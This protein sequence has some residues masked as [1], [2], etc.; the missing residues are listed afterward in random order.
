MFL[1][2]EKVFDT[3]WESGI[4]HKLSESEFST[5]FI[6]LI[7]SFL[8]DRT[9]KVLVEGKISTPRKIAAGL[10]QRSVLA[11]ILYFLYINE[12]PA[13][14]G[15][16]LALFADD[17]CIYPAE[18]HKRRVLCKLQRGLTAVNSWCERWNRKLKEGKT[19][20]RLR[21]LDAVIQLNERD[22]PFVNNEM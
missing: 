20:T 18:K 1:D 16:H 15:V 8:T 22:S 6:K 13:A 3:T 11:P 4:L 21:V 2:I 14:P 12:A 5:S 10:P 9:F 17:A 19:H 7:A